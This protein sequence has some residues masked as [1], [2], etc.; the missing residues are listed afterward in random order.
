MSY[1]EY[2]DHY[3]TVTTEDV[4]EKHKEGS[5]N[6]YIQDNSCLICGRSENDFKIFDCRKWCAMLA[7]NELKAKE[8]ITA[9]RNEY[10]KNELAS[11]Y[12]NNIVDI[13]GN[14]DKM[15]RILFIYIVS[16]TH[17]CAL[18]GIK[19]IY[20]IQSLKFNEEFKNITEEQ[21]VIR[22][23]KAVELLKKVELLEKD[24]QFEE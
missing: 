23:D 18:S 5:P 21:L 22:I 13:L 24:Q 20:I 6:N 4:K 7:L 16:K 10:I 2:I 3:D 9:L 11:A 1:K 19:R 8:K 15:A 17:S 12:V 14:L